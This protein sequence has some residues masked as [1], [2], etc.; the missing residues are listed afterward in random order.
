MNSIEQFRARRDERIKNRKD[1]DDIQWIS[2][3]EGSHIPLKNGKSVGGWSKGKDFSSAKSE[4]KEAK[5]KATPTQN[6]SRDL[7]KCKSKNEYRYA[8]NR[9]AKGSKVYIQN[10]KMVEGYEKTGEGMYGQWKRIYGTGNIGEFVDGDKLG[11]RAE[12][13]DYCGTTAK[14]ARKAY[15]EVFPRHH[16]KYGT[17]VS[18][19]GK[20]RDNAEAK[21]YKGLTGKKEL[22]NALNE[23]YP[24]KAESAFNR[25][26]DNNGIDATNIEYDKK[27][28]RFKVETEISNGKGKPKTK[29]TDYY[30][31]SVGGGK[32]TIVQN[33]NPK[34][35]ERDVIGQNE[36]PKVEYVFNFKFNKINPDVDKRPY[37][38]DRMIKREEKK[39]KVNE[40][41]G[42]ELHSKPSEK[43]R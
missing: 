10:G 6:L 16:E 12:A 19:E 17:R 7:K 13:S 22:Y 40:A 30:G 3:E 27:H 14:T 11:I 29:Q 23:E 31:M 39:K 18:S 32:Y 24:W 21:Y 20:S 33:R 25:Y 1:A 26:L 34:F 41:I 36:K 38:P 5:G 35:G 15:Q 43:Y 9:A 2:T 4:K 42:K 37:S 8:L 28:K